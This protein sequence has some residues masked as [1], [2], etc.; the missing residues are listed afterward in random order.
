MSDTVTDKLPDAPKEEIVDGEKNEDLHKIEIKVKGSKSIFVDFQYFS[1]RS[2]VFSKS[3][4]KGDFKSSYDYGDTFLYS[5]VSNFFKAV[6]GIKP[7]IT[8]EIVFEYLKLCDI[9]DIASDIRQFGM[10]YY[11]ENQQ[12]LIIPRVLFKLKHG[13]DYTSDLE[14]L[15]QNIIS[16][17]NDKNL[18]K[19][20]PD[21]LIK[22]VDF[23]KVEDMNE[24]FDSLFK[25]CLEY[26]DNHHK[27]GED[28]SSIFRTLNVAKLSTEKMHNL[29][30]RPY[31][32]RS[33]LKDSCGTFIKK[34]NDI[35]EKGQNVIK[36]CEDE[37]LKLAEYDSKFDEYKTQIDHLIAT[38]KQQNLIIEGLLKINQDVQTISISPNQNAICYPD[39]NNLNSSRPS[40]SP[41]NGW[42]YLDAY[43]GS[44]YNY[45]TTQGQSF[46]ISGYSSTRSNA[47]S[48]FIPID[49][50]QSFSY[51]GSFSNYYTIPEK[52]MKYVGYPDWTRAESKA[53]NSFTASEDGWLYAECGYNSTS[54]YASI[55]G[56]FSFIISGS[57][58]SSWMDYSSVF[59]PIS[60]G[61]SI[62]FGGGSKE[63]NVVFVP[64]NKKKIVNRPDWSRKQSCSWNSI[65]YASENGWIYARASHYSPT[66]YET[67][68]LIVGGIKFLIH[69]NDSQHETASVFVPVEKGQSFHA[70][71][72]YQNQELVFIPSKPN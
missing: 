40:T 47:H 41:Y 49:V 34:F 50:N 39:W 11:E 20:P 1:F 60:K 58:D 4:W 63:K 45:L 19:L 56:K 66:S 61:D 65:I 37:L 18:P 22:C 25:Y 71:G 43:S 32:N 15:S 31:F 36:Q 52:S 5:S 38:T 8:D 16:F 3:I 57:S 68:Y 24:G 6:Q 72:G 2:K 59:F 69:R 64:E 54:A 17:L 10:T 42:F 55:N 28:V 21:V 27:K 9:W 46:Y 53:W 30:S 62:S 23:Q 7:K 12:K 13:D 26:L 29:C 14:Y 33:V 70:F 48:L 35:K 67:A 44:D 51:S